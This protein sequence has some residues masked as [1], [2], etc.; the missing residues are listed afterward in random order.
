MNYHKT[1]LLYL[2]SNSFRN[3]TMKIYLLP[4]NSVAMT[5]MMKIE[6]LKTEKANL[7]LQIG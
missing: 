7:C 4:L 6:Q 1:P 5:S 3:E 2:L